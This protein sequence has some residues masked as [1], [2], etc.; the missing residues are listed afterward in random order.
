MQTTDALGNPIIMLG[1]YGYSRNVNGISHV[2]VGQIGR[3]NNDGKVRLVN[4]KLNRSL[5]GQPIEHSEQPPADVSIRANMIFP[6]DPTKM[7]NF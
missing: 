4:C 5:Y 7:Q 1:W 3:Y 2:L 6:V